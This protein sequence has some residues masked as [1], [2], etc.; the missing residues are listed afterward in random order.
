MLGGRA[1]FDV[2][3]ITMLPVEQIRRKRSSQKLL[4]FRL[5]QVVC[6]MLVVSQ[7]SNDLLSKLANMRDAIGLILPGAVSAYLVSEQ[8][9][10]ETQPRS[11]LYV[12]VSHLCSTKAWP[13]RCLQLR[14]VR[15][16]LDALK[17]CS[18]ARRFRTASILMAS[19]NIGKDIPPLPAFERPN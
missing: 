11:V 18:G 14:L 17:L 4:T 6:D 15:I 13:I 8:L 5:A 2:N 1:G 10:K 12:G 7:S 19:C 3:H 9:H 16:S